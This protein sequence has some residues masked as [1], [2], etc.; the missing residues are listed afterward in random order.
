[1]VQTSSTS[2]TQTT[3]FQAE[4][5]Q[6]VPNHDLPSHHHQYHYQYNQYSYSV[7]SPRLPFPFPLAPAPRYNGYHHYNPPPYTYPYYWSQASILLY[8]ITIFLY[9]TFCLL[10]CK[11]H[12]LHFQLAFIYACCL[13]VAYL[14]LNSIIGIK[15]SN[16][17][18][19][20]KV[21]TKFAR[22]TLSEK[23]S[24]SRSLTKF[25]NERIQGT[26]Y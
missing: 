16:S 7:S 19:H 5:V 22:S 21:F 13:L 1:M 20:W 25:F 18:L 24:D 3:M 14:S 4:A 9:S 15:L 23:D 2:F 8:S 26:I 12:F 17:F 11:I 10:F 6:H